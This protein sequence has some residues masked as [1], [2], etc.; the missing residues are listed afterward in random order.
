MSEITLTAEVG[1]TTGSSATR[2][3][4]REGK[5][6]AV[7]YG[8]GSEPLSVAV[9]SSDL[10][11]ALTGLTIAELISFYE[12]FERTEKTVTCY[13]QGVNQSESG[14]D[15]VNAIINCHLATGRIGQPGMGPFSLTGQPNA[16]GGREVGALSNTLAAHMEFGAADVDRVGRFW[17]APRMATK[18]GLKAVDLFESVGRGEIKAIWIMATNPVVSLPNADSVR[19]ALQVCELSVVSEAVRNSD[20]V[21]ACRIR[22]PALAWGEKDG[23]VTNSERGISRQRPFLRAPGEARQD[24]WILSQVARR[25]GH[26]DA[27]AWRGVADIFRARV[28]DATPGSFVFELTGAT[29]KLDA[30]LEALDRSAILETVRTGVCGIGRGERILRV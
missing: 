19:R 27:F 8:H 16:M 25:L 9:D 30:F 18:P 17:R 13:S 1:R 4:R 6:P 28:I 24:W 7:V 29:D 3:L 23:T 10:R 22:L 2:R 12:L 15:K 5:I 14:T 11:V 26:G 20:T 21:D